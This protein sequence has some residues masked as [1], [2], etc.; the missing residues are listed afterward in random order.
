[1]LRC[2]L[3]PINRLLRAL[4]HALT[5]IIPPSQ[6][7]LRHVDSLLGGFAIPINGH[8][9]VLRN[10]VA[11]GAAG[12]E[13]VLRR[14]IALLRRLTQPFRRL[15]CALLHPLAVVIPPSQVVLGCAVPLFGGFPI[16]IS[17]LDPVLRNALAV[18]AANA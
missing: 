9:P 10:S 3:E 15:L 17:G 14:S 13:L 1:M 8:L 12:A 18:G 2:L 7:V 4:L 6:V 5:L 11:V 16:P